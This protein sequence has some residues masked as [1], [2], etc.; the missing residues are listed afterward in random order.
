MTRDEYLNACRNNK[1]NPLA[2]AIT[3]LSN[4]VYC[5]YHILGY[6]LVEANT[7]DSSLFLALSGE[8]GSGKEK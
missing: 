3:E 2:K 6:R 4:E 7:P 8:K 5:D 1:I